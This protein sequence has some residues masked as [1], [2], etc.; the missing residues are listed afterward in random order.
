MGVWGGLFGIG[1]VVEVVN[2]RKGLCWQ[3]I[4]IFGSPY[5]SLLKVSTE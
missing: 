3:H 4:D 1:E 2:F 5:S